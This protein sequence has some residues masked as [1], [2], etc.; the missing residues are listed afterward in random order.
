MIAMIA[1]A[2]TTVKTEMTAVEETTET[3][4]MIVETETI[5]TI[6]A[7]T[8]RQVRTML[9]AR[10]ENVLHRWKRWKQSHPEETIPRRNTKKKRKAAHRT[11]GL[12]PP[13]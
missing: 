9:A 5:E 10:E 12:L 13:F 6:A 4:E 2:E 7:E 8:D 11:G 1:A 3:T